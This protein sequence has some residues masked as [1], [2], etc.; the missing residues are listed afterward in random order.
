M[1]DLELNNIN[2]NLETDLA[3]TAFKNLLER[4]NSERVTVNYDTGNSAGLG[5]D[6]E[7]EFSAYGYRITDIHIKDRIMD[8]F[9]VCLGQGAADFAKIFKCIQ[10]YGYTGPFIM[11]AFRDDDGLE[12]FKT[13]LTWL[14]S[15]IQNIDESNGD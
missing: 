7:Q 14:R 15:L 9:S 13:Q 5:Y 10:N 2:L 11:Q 8:G 12:I 6:A 1:S 3:P 4:F